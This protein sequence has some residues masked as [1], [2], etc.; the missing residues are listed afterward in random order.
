M[1]QDLEDICIEYNKFDDKI[2]FINKKNLFLN[3]NQNIFASERKCMNLKSL[4]EKWSKWEISTLKM[5]MIHSVFRVQDEPFAEYDS[6]KPSPLFKVNQVGYL[7]DAPKFAYAGAWLGPKFGAWKPR[8]PMSAW[9]LVD[10]STGGVV[11]RGEGDSAPRVRVPDGA[12][13]EGAP[14]TGEETYEMDF[15]SVTN[16]GTYFV[17]I[18]GVGRSASF[19]IAASA[20]ED[21]FRVHMGGLY[22]KRCGIAK[23]NL[24]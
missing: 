8:K 13:K 3:T 1:K 17:R 18:P 24:R 10:A 4:Y 9:E 14:F 12:T 23:E 5:L 6:A 21:A 11:L 15:S 2:G 16:E 22:Q 20:A 7:P 19:R